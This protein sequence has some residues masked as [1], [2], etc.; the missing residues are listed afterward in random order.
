MDERS[1]IFPKKLKHNPLKK[2]HSIKN[3]QNKSLL[4]F[5]IKYEMGF[6]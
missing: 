4:I 1:N 5:F 6:A 2:I 3:F